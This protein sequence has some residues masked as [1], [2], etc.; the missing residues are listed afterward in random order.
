MTAKENL[1]YAFLKTVSYVVDCIS[2]LKMSRTGKQRTKVD[3]LADQS[4]CIVSF[5][6]IEVAISHS[7]NCSSVQ[8]FRTQY[9]EA[10]QKTWHYT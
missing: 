4:I 7:Q 1:I 10:N 6:T 3:E 8:E 9:E 5:S 2:V